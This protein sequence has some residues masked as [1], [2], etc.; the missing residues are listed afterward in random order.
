MQVILRIKRI[1]G[2]QNFAVQ[3]S[4][5]AYVLDALEQAQ[6]SD[7]SLLF[8]H[9][10]H[11][12]SC[13]SCGMRINGDERLACATRVVDMVGRGHS[14]TLEPL[15]NL[16]VLGDL[17]VDPGPLFARVETSGLPLVR[18]AGAGQGGRMAGVFEDCIECGL[19]VSACPVAATDSAFVG[20]A[21]LAAAA[22]AARAEGASAQELRASAAGEHGLWR[23]HAAFEC[24]RVCPAQ[25]D[26]SKAIME[27]R[28][29]LVRGEA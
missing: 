24:T 22:R 28:A 29:R 3:V 26:P 16:P 4:P 10:C 14:I 9:S 2:W 18:A 6:R 13:G 15:R 1:R 12:S 21:A 20:P 25:V 27:W 19:C 5:D 8:R 11:H 7:P 23:C 17:L